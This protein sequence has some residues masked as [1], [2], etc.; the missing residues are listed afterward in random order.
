VWRLRSVF[1]ARSA[2]YLIHAILRTILHKRAKTLR[3]PF[4]IILDTQEV[5]P[6][7]LLTKHKTILVTQNATASLQAPGVASAERIAERS[8]DWRGGGGMGKGTQPE[9]VYYIYQTDVA[10]NFDIFGPTTLKPSLGSD[11]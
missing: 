6:R 7:V 11:W 5:D 3:Q 10:I 9:P 8:L 2:G 1:Q 4:E